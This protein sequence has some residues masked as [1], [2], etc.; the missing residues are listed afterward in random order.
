MQSKGSLTA[1]VTAGIQAM[2][3]A[4]E[5][6]DGQKGV[7]MRAV[8]WTAEKNSGPNR[9]MGIAIAYIVPQTGWCG[10][11]TALVRLESRPADTSIGRTWI[12]THARIA[13]AGWVDLKFVD[14]FNLGITTDH[15]P[16]KTWSETD[17]QM[18]QISMKREKA[19]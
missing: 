19:D 17:Y 11:A 5:H 18:L 10:I 2:I 9:K 14:G 4:M 1:S 6:M 3:L 7:L 12:P 13:Y 8:D 15:N 16:E